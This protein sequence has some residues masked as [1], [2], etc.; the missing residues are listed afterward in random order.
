MKRDMDLCREILKAVEDH[1][2]HLVNIDEIVARIE[3]PRPI[4]FHHCHVMFEAGL[5][6]EKSKQLTRRVA[7]PNYRAPKETFDPDKAYFEI[8]DGTWVAFSLTWEGHEFLDESRNDEHWNQA[9]DVVRKSG[10]WSFSII[11]DV[12]KSIAIE[13]CKLS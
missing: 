6:D 2:S 1:E 7:N 3:K 12:L 8:H 5:L 11:A 4:C 10:T 9:K 13:A